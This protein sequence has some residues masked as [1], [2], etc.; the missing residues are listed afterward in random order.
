M[1]CELLPKR[2]SLFENNIVEICKYQEPI[3][4]SM[5]PNGVYYSADR[6]VLTGN[7]LATRFEFTNRTAFLSSMK[8]SSLSTATA[9]L[10]I[11]LTID[12]CRARIVMPLN[13]SVSSRNL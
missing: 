13:I 3:I 11:S 1:C 8:E 9:W 2:V 5:S 12:S 7:Y 10:H 6:N 4:V